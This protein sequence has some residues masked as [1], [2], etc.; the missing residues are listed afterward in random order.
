MSAGDFWL[1]GETFFD[2]SIMKRDFSKIYQQQL[3]TPKDPDENFDFMFGEVNNYYQIS[4]LQFEKTLKK[5]DGKI[6]GDKTDLNRLVSI[7]FAQPFIVATIIKTVDW[8][9]EQNI[10]VGNFSLSRRFRV[11]TEISPP[12]LMKLR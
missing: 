10:Y 6:E 3:S 4:Q 9:T 1:T 7:A 5:K 2:Y 11:K 12:T 8:E